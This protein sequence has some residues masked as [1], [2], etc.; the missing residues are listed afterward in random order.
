MFSWGWWEITSSDMPQLHLK[1]A[2]IA[3]TSGESCTGDYQ[4]PWM[5]ISRKVVDQDKIESSLWLCSMMAKE[6]DMLIL[7]LTIKKNKK[8]LQH[9]M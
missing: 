1:W 6:E 3:Q 5:S 8:T 4:A 9:I 2:L 7:M